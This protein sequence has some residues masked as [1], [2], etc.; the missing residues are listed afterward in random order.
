MTTEDNVAQ[1][2]TKSNGWGR[3]H[4][5]VLN[6]LQLTSTK[7]FSHSVIHYVKSSSAAR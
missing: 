1:R 3:S 7:A 4:A 2:E 6:K 5:R